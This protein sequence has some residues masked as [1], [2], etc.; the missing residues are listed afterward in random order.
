MNEEMFV[1]Q[2]ARSEEP[3][4][5]WG[6]GT[7]LASGRRQVVPLQNQMTETAVSLPFPPNRSQ[8]RNI[9]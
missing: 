6:V 3:C 2:V 8:G 1:G 7:K 9:L 4:W 5:G